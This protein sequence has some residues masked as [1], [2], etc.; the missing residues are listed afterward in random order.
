MYNPKNWYPDAIIGLSALIVTAALVGGW[1]VVAATAVGLVSL[2]AF[3]LIFSGGKRDELRKDIVSKT[4]AILLVI[5]SLPLS[6]PLW[7]FA[8]AA[9]C[10]AAVP[11]IFG[12]SANLPFPSSS[13]TNAFL[14]VAFPLFMSLFPTPMQKLPTFANVADTSLSSS[15]ESYIARYDAFPLLPSGGVY[16]ILLGQFSGGIGVK[17]GMLVGLSLVIMLFRRSLPISF[18]APAI[19]LFTVLILAFPAYSGAPL[20]AEWFVF[21]FVFSVL[22]TASQPTIMPKTAL[23]RL[24]Y[25]IIFAFTLFGYRQITTRAGYLPFAC[26]TAGILAR[27]C[28]YLAEMA[29]EMAHRLAM[30]PI[31]DL[32]LYET[33]RTEKATVAT[34][35]P[36]IEQTMELDFMPLNVRVSRSDGKTVRVKKS[37]SHKSSVKKYHLQKKF[38]SAF[39]KLFVRPDS[40]KIVPLPKI[41]KK[42][43]LPQTPKLGENPDIIRENMTDDTENINE[44]DTNE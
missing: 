35:R 7:L 25:G 20:Y 44:E 21:P 24:F 27:K 14:I 19:G 12:G 18:A 3:E 30:V 29:I 39:V 41:Q 38:V 15:L 34:S 31:R 37:Q 5:C 43:I 13:F 11:R 42:I 22:F 17:Y 26:V 2:A 8:F 4:A 1:R 10:C 16:G 6:A 36:Q 28:D 23:G 32:S 33:A 40:E 9:L